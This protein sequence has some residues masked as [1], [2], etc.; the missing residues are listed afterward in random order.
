MKTSTSIFKIT[1]GSTDAASRRGSNTKAPARN[2]EEMHRAWSMDTLPPPGMVVTRP[3]K[4]R[5]AF[6]ASSS[7]E[8]SWQVGVAS[9][10]VFMSL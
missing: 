8:G 4:K 10:F 1:H 7:M 9:L 6:G 3:L 5:G 2:V